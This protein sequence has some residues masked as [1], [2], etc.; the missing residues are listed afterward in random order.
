MNDD[1]DKSEKFNKIHN[2]AVP[3]EDDEK[4]EHS[5]GYI[6]DDDSDDDIISLEDDSSD[7]D[8]EGSGENLNHEMEKKNI[9]SFAH[10]NTNKTEVMIFKFC[11]I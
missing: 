3:P 6:S 4:L 5:D 7:E 1:K 10:R 9:R 2:E 11:Q 8:L